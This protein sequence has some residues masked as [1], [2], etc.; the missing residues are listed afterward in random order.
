VHGNPLKYVDPTGEALVLPLIPIGI[1]KIGAAGLGIGIGVSGYCYFT[2]CTSNDTY[3]TES[4]EDE[5]SC[6]AQDL[7]DLTGLDEEEV[8]KILKDAGFEPSSD[9]VPD[10]YQPWKHPDGSLVNIRPDGEISRAGPRQPQQH[11]PHNSPWFRPRFDPAGNEIPHSPGADTHA[12]GE[13][14]NLN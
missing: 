6:A 4:T 1:G 13:F 3:H 14:I 12:T 9:R 7:P 8:Q 5:K 11:D 2:G 10:K